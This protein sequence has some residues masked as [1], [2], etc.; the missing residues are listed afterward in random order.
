MLLAV[1]ATWLA[2][3]LLSNPNRLLTV[4]ARDGVLVQIMR[5][6]HGL[7]HEVVGRFRI[8]AGYGQHGR[9]LIIGCAE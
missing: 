8:E 5:V 2:P 4:F 9:I 3:L 1:I 7:Y 6:C